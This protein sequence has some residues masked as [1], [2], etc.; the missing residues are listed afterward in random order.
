M[1]FHSIVLWTSWTVSSTT[2]QRLAI[3]VLCTLFI[4]TKQLLS[5]ASQLLAVFLFR[6][7]GNIPSIAGGTGQQQ[8]APGSYQWWR[9][10][11]GDTS[12]V[13]RYRQQSWLNLT[14]NVEFQLHKSTREAGKRNNDCVIRSVGCNFCFGW[15]TKHEGWFN[16]RCTCRCSTYML[17]TRSVAEAI[18]KY[19]RSYTWRL[20]QVLRHHQPA[21]RKTAPEVQTEGCAG[22]IHHA[23][24]VCVCA[25]IEDSMW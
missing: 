4:M 21:N 25:D 18:N 5:C 1:S 24:V 8:G 22:T 16:L 3:D 10:S 7:T 6:V 13:P 23:V 9:R 17:T 20:Q 2:V 14:N 11:N 15:D 12:S 19:N